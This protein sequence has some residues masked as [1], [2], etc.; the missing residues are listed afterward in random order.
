MCQNNIPLKPQDFT[1]SAYVLSKNADRILLM[2]H[3]KIGLWLAP[4]G[5]LEGWEVPH[6]AALREVRE[7]TGVQARIVNP[8]FELG[9]HNKMETQLPT[10]LFVWEHRIFDRETGKQQV[11]EHLDLCYLAQALD[12][13]VVVNEAE[14]EGVQWFTLEQVQQLET[15][16]AVKKVCAF[17]LG[18]LCGAIEQK[19]TGASAIN[20]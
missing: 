6:E 17:V 1:A 19:V 8:Y 2:L 5:H 15:T 13:S 11:H 9:V 10:P 7:E 3:K 12:E 4:G 14:S 18:Q 20:I 16:E